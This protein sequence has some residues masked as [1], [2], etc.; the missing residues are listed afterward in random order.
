MN[1][2]TKAGRFFNCCAPVEIN[3]TC[4][5]AAEPFVD[6]AHGDYAL[7]PD[8]EVF[9]RIPGFRPIPLERIGLLTKRKHD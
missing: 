3:T 5:V 2:T 7:R 1:D 8:S 4:V 6:A 9:R